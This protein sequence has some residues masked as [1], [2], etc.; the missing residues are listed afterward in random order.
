MES[1]RALLNHSSS[2]GGKIN[3]NPTVRQ[4]SQGWEFS[5][6]RFQIGP[7]DTSV[8]GPQHPGSL[9]RS[10]VA[11]GELSP[12]WRTASRVSSKGDMEV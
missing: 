5:C 2:Y 1:A 4:I 12:A 8:G 6:G 11:A 3:A 10:R 9:G 7:A